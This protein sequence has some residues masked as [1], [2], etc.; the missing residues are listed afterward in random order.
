MA[1]CTV[2]FF[3]GFNRFYDGSFRR[4]HFG[5]G[6]G[7]SNLSLP[8]AAPAKGNCMRLT[9]QMVAMAIVMIL[10]GGMAWAEEKKPATLEER[11]SY[12]LGVRMGTDFKERDFKIVPDLVTQGMQDALE[13]K[14]TLMTMEEAEGAMM[15]FQQA[16]MAKVTEQNRAQGEAFLMENAKKEGVVTTE[17]GLQYEVLQEGKGEPPT[18]TDKVKVDYEGSLLSGQVFDSSYQRGDPASFGVDQVI[19]GWTE[20]LQLMKPGSMYKLYVPSQLAYGDQGAGRSIG[21]GQTLVFQVELLEIL[22]QE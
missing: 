21:P 2:I 19:K 4:P 22:P 10:V 11:F 6:N 16:A 12:A 1:A 7:A 5:R 13:G 3:F 8:A 14:E 17:S 20:G 15:E 9:R 18:A